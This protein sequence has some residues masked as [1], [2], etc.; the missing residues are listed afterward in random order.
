MI[1]FV[2]IERAGGTTL[3]YVFRHN[4]FSFVT[5]T[6]WNRWT[7]E[8]ANVFT[9]AEA[10][11]LFRLLPFVKAFGGHTTRSYLGYEDAIG[12]PI[13]Y[14]T[15]L[16]E[17]VSRYL[18]HFKYQNRVMGISW[19]MDE[20]LNEPRFDNFI[21]TRIAGC[22]DLELAKQ[23]LA[24]DFLFVGL[25]GRFDE[26]LVLMKHLI[27]DRDFD[28][29]YSARNAVPEVSREMDLGPWMD[30]IREQNALDIELYRFV[31]E[32]LY[33]R[34]ITQYGPSFEADTA[35]FRSHNTGNRFP[36]WLKVSRGVYRMLFYRNV[37]RLVR[38]RYHDQ[39]V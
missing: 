23:R 7:N 13:Q 37:E 26:S 3:H 9:A 31:E 36:R 10:R 32:T 27:D 18:S 14:V 22:E 6:P 15:F 11:A 38:A 28:I 24:E 16:R 30:R 17:P 35:A 4:Y 2:H 25:T 21:T 20:F 29:Y 12:K 5:L 8:E 34:F 39:P 33:P 19:T 1:C